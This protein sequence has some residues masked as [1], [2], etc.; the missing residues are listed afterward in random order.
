M[1]EEEVES[2][3]WFP[4]VIGGRNW[5]WIIWIVWICGV[6]KSGGISLYSFWKS[7]EERG[8]KNLERPKGRKETNQVG[9]V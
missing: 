9:F 4:I 8:G 1:V 7:T 5:N 3:Q 2:L 6:G